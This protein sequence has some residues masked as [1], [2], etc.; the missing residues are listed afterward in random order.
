MSTL[1]DRLR[2]KLDHLWAPDHMSAYVDEDLAL[3]GR[4]RM[5]RHAGECQECRRLLASLR[6]ML[7]SLHRLPAP[8]RS[9]DAPQIAAAV[10]LRL[11]EP[12]AR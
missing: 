3:D 8:S 12:P 2:F 5:E 9:A 7:D 1:L 11:S 10:R 6:R 4:R